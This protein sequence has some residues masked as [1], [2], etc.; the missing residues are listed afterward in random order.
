MG[1]S[2]RQQIVAYIPGG[3]HN[4]QKFAVVLVR[5]GRTRDLPGLKYK[6]R[7]GSR[8][9]FSVLNRRHSRSKYGTKRTLGRIIVRTAGRLPRLLPAAF[10]WRRLFPFVAHQ[11]I[12][13]GLQ[14][15]PPFN[16]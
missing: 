3:E 5:G 13:L 12:R 7:R 1:L 14:V 11:S 16:A 9:L 15:H 4:L 8:D 10:R 2:N 6:L